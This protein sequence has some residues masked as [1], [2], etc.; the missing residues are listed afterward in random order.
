MSLS[1]KPLLALARRLSLDGFAV[2]V[3]A[4]FIVLVLAGIL[5]RIPW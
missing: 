4:S 5:P 1:T 3:A 2:F